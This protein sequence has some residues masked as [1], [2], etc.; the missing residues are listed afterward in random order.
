MAK[1]SRNQ[2]AKEKV[3]AGVGGRA[4]YLLGAKPLMIGTFGTAFA[5]GKF[6]QYTAPTKRMRQAGKQEAKDAHR[7]WKMFKL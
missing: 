2:N 3:F 4:I 1:K 6:S 7:Y 5:M